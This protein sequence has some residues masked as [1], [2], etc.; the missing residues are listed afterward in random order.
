MDFEDTQIELNKISRKFII[1]QSRAN[2]L[3]SGKGHV[4]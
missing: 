2:D 3:E 4:L 1:E